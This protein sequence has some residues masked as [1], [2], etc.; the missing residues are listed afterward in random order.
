MQNE[1]RTQHD[2]LQLARGLS[3]RPESV[4]PY[5]HWELEHAVFGR[6]HAF[7]HTVPADGGDTDGYILVIDGGGHRSGI[8]TDGQSMPQIIADHLAEAGHNN[9]EIPLEQLGVA[10]RLALTAFDAGTDA[11][12][13]ATVDYA[14]YLLIAMQRTRR[15]STSGTEV[16]ARNHRLL[17]PPEPGR[18][19]S[20][21]CPFCGRPAIHQDRYPRSVC[22]SCFPRTTDRAG[23]PVV[24]SNVSFSGGFVAH[25]ADPPREECVEVTRTGR[26][27]I[28]GREATMGEARFGGIVVQALDDAAG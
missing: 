19:Y 25:Y 5:G 18:R 21:P 4:R 6:G 26:C 14:Q 22:D 8:L 17:Q 1:G 15:R 24:G 20:H 13:A 12:D 10:Q 2:A 28:D 23:R 3:R 9:R 11:L 27:Y 7:L 16:L